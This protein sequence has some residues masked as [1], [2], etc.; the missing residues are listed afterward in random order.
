[1]SVAGRSEFPSQAGCPNVNSYSLDLQVKTVTRIVA[2]DSLAAP[3]DTVVLRSPPANSIVGLPA[4]RLRRYEG[5]AHGAAKVM[6]G[7]ASTGWPVSMI[8]TRDQM[9]NGRWFFASWPHP[10]VQRTGFC[11]SSR[12]CFAYIGLSI[13]IK[14]SSQAC[15][16][17]LVLLL[18][19]GSMRLG[20]V[21]WATRLPVCMSKFAR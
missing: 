10:A 21:S 12:P 17:L 20:F 16:V 19:T 15:Y 3:C 7:H 14:P 9:C 1:M 11:T 18:A 2:M 8:V 5:R 4:V 13:S 6:R